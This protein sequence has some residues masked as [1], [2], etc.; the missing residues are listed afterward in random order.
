MPKPKSPVRKMREGS[1]R[2]KLVSRYRGWDCEDGIGER[3]VIKESV[4]KVMRRA[5][6]ALIEILDAPEWQEM[7]LAAFQKRLSHG[8]RDA[9]RLYPEL[10]KMVGPEKQL[11]VI[12]HERY[13]V[14]SEE[15]L[16]KLVSRVREADQMSD[17]QRFER[18]CEWLRGYLVPNPERV[19]YARDY[20]LGQHMRVDDVSVA[21]VVDE[22]EGESGVDGG[23][24]L[25][26]VR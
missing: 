8:A 1:H 15:E 7:W 12:L 26:E 14:R 13:G 6:E 11:T 25:P 9:V 17:E 16:E 22:A 20:V 3:T 10:L 21:R 24:R 5:P 18:T 19:E 2:P 4:R 23:V